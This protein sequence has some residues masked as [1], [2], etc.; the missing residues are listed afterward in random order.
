MKEFF[1]SLV[2]AMVEEFVPPQAGDR[3]QLGGDLRVTN[4]YKQIDY[5]AVIF[6]GPWLCATMEVR[7]GEAVGRTHVKW[8]VNLF[9]A[10]L[11]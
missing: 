11:L 8:T 6:N 4:F 9:R 3:S 1:I 2:G 7:A 10:T 5:K